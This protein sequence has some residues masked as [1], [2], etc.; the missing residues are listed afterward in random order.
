MFRNN[1]EMPQADQGE[2][3]QGGNY[4]SL[5]KLEHVEFIVGEIL[6]GS[7]TGNY[8]RSYA[9]APEMLLPGLRKQVRESIQHNYHSV[10]DEEVVTSIISIGYINNEVSG[11]C[12]ST[13]P[14]AKTF[15]LHML[16]VGEG[17]RN[18]GLG[19]A[20]LQDAL[21]SFPE[22]SQ[23]IARIYKDE[24]KTDHSRSMLNILAEEGFTEPAEQPNTKTTLFSK[25][26]P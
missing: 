3:N 11:F 4:T 19:K 5:A 7:A 16:S 24:F 18:M 9:I 15:E 8:N 25:E 22:G 20:L 2:N 13:K 21:A 26:L 14:L 6:K 23:V 1:R 10:S 17:K 12:W